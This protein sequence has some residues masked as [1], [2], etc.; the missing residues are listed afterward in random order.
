MNVSLGVGLEGLSQWRPAGRAEPVVVSER[1]NWPFL[2]VVTSLGLANM[3]QFGKR[4]RIRKK[5]PHP[6]N[7]PYDFKL[8]YGFKLSRQICECL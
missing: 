1:A 2:H 7:A 6:S 3:R 4:G 5:Y 8:R